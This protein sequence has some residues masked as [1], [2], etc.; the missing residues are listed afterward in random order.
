MQANPLK[1]QGRTTTPWE[2]LEQAD[3]GVSAL[4]D[5][6]VHSTTP[7][8][9]PESG[10]ERALTL[11]QQQYA[12]LLADP[13]KASRG[14]VMTA[15]HQVVMQ[16]NVRRVD[17]ERLVERLTDQILDAGPLA[18]YFRDPAVT[19]IMV[20]GANVFVEKHG[21][22]ERATAL[23]S[24]NAG[25]R[26]AQHLARHQGLEYKSSAPLM[27]FTWARDGSRINI[28]HHDKSPT[29]VAISIRKRNQE[30][31]LDLPDLIAGRM[32]SVEAAY[33]LL[34]ALAGRLNVIFSGPPGAGKTSL[35]RA[36]AM[37]AILS[38]ERV[39]T[40]EDTE[41]LRLLLPH[42]VALIGQT[43]K[44]TAEERHQGVVSLQELFRNTLRMRYDRLIIGEL[45]GPEAFDFLEAAMSSEGGMMSSIH[46]RTPEILVDRLYQ[47]SHKYQMGM[48]YD[49]IS[50]MVYDTTDII[51][52]VERDGHY[53]RH[54]T[55]IVEAERD[56][57][58]RD[59]FRWNPTTQKVETVAALS[60]RRMEWVTAH[61]RQ[62]LD[63]LRDK[64]PMD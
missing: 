34:L 64:L 53:H 47:I 54:I 60:D 30:R 39:I 56:G 24:L 18:P 5:V 22:I 52:Q 7:E 46:L 6:V 11:L 44:P 14:D 42:L 29:G 15:I 41:E 28:V 8:D 38:E 13:Q 20:N 32:L 21:Q 31:A 17:A 10:Y 37:G 49:L 23:S 48:P 40:M 2:R 43:D 62:D 3:T 59:L 55:R 16:L 51:V 19:E 36:V 9:S 12:T 25:I 1:P 33:L 50:H 26:L 58:M 63:S 4:P 57:S 61:L 45:R 35:I 27:N